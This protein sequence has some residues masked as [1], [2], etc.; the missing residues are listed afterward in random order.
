MTDQERSQRIIE[1]IKEAGGRIDWLSDDDVILLNT[2]IIN[3][4]L[5]EKLERCKN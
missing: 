2:L 4:Q 1:Q 3:H 5:L